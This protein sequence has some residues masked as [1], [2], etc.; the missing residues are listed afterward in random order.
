MSNRKYSEKFKKSAVKLV[1]DLGYSYNEAAIMTGKK[2][3]QV[4]K[5]NDEKKFVRLL[6]LLIKKA[7][8]FYGYRK[9]YKDVIEAVD[10]YCCPETV[11][12]VLAAEGMKSHTVRKHLYPKSHRNECFALNL[13]SRKFTANAP[14][15]KWVSDITYIPTGE[16]WLYLAIVQ[17]IFSR[18]IVS[19]SMSSRVDA[20]LACN[21]LDMAVNQPTPYGRGSFPLRPREPVYQFLLCIDSSQTWLCNQHEVDEEIAGIMLSQRTF[22]ANLKRDL[23]NRT[24]YKTREQAR[25]DIFYLP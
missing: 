13:L 25:Q 1:T 4:N 17:D 23:V 19:W 6:V 3:Y 15:K 22:S 21:A 20:E 2:G 12:R 10:F 9:V 11:R 24:V 18:K 7:T 14:N 8:A 16:C 5:R